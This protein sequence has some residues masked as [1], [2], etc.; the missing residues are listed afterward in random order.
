MAEIVIHSDYY[1]RTL[2]ELCGAFKCL[3]VRSDDEVVMK[4]VFF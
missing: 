1:H 3:W 2:F 4:F